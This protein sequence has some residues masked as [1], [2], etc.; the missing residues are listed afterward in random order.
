[1]NCPHC[2]QPT[3]IDPALMEADKCTFCPCCNEQIFMYS[4]HD[5]DDSEDDNWQPCDNCDLPDAC[6][7]FGCAIK[8]GIKKHPEF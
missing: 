2:G 6:E 1:M 8:A 7:D 4:L 5:D 3:G